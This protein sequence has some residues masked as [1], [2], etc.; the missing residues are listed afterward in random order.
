[1]ALDPQQPQPWYALS[2]VH[3][4]LGDPGS[5]RQAVDRFRRLSAGR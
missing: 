5:A 2:R 1:M 3:L 4:R